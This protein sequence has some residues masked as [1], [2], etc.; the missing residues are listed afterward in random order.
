VDVSGK[1]LVTF[2]VFALGRKTLYDAYGFSAGA[3][4]DADEIYTNR[5]HDCQVIVETW[6]TKGAYR[7]LE[8]KVHV[9]QKILEPWVRPQQVE[10]WVHCEA[11]HSMPHRAK[12]G[13]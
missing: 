11:W 7:R 3:R 1:C 13:N 6:D 12:W 5:V 8:M 2:N 9:A 10:E 4:H